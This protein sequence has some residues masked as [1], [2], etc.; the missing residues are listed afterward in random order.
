[1]ALKLQQ[2]AALQLQFKCTNTNTNSIELQLTIHKD[3][4]GG[5]SQLTIKI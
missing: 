3:A 4:K 5:V 2:K 1:M